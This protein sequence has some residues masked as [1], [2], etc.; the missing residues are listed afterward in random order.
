MA[1]PKKNKRNTDI[2]LDDAI[3]AENFE[4]E[5]EE[6]GDDEEEEATKELDFDAD[7]AYGRMSD[8][9]DESGDWN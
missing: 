1:A 8:F 3:L 4:P 9:E 6:L 7:S 2:D 5:L